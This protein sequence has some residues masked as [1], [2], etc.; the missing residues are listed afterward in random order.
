VQL[1]VFTNTA[2]TLVNATRTDRVKTSR[3]WGDV[4]LADGGPVDLST[5][6]DTCRRSRSPR[7]F[8]DRAVRGDYFNVFAVIDM[9]IPRLKRTLL[10]GTRWGGPDAR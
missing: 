9:T 4:E 3:T 8:V 7:T 2:A 10:V 1:R 5:V 6:C